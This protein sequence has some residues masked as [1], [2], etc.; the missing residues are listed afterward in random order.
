MLNS[1]HL[2]GAAKAGLNFICNK[3][4]AFA[5]TNVPDSMEEVWRCR[6]ISALS[7]Y[8]PVAR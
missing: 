2:A 3:Q 6:N 7:E 4:Y 8:G 5:V 1:E